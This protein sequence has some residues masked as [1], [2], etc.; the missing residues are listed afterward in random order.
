MSLILLSKDHKSISD[1]KLQVFP[2]TPFGMTIA[3]YSLVTG[4]IDIFNLC[5]KA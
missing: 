2:N 5:G 4:N 1:Y 3:D